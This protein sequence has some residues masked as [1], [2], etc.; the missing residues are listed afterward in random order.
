MDQMVFLLFLALCNFIPLLLK[1]HF[2]DGK[3]SLGCVHT[4]CLLCIVTVSLSLEVN[5]FLQLEVL[6]YLYDLQISDLYDAVNLYIVY[7]LLFVLYEESKW[8][9]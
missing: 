3:W 5:P 9:I 1:I 7:R 6:N 8:G 2:G 4:E